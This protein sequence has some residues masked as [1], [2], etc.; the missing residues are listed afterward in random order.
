MLVRLSV[1][2]QG[3]VEATEPVGPPWH[4]VRPTLPKGVH[5]N[6]SSCITPREGTLVGYQTHNSGQQ[7]TIFP[8]FSGVQG[9][10]LRN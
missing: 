4:K 1:E 3:R 2:R 5:M 8:W 6:A 9:K 10:G 7:E